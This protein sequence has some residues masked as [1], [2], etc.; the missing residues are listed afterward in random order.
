MR[1]SK[2]TP[3][4]ILQ[5]LRQAEGGTTVVDICRK[6]GVTETTFYRWKK[7]YTG[8]DVSELREL[9]QLREENRRLKT[10]VADLTLDKT[11]LRDA[12]GKKW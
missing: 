6:M 5:A 10:A 7:Q 4:Q 2:F 1:K 8:L 9:K 11:I 12:L 3:E